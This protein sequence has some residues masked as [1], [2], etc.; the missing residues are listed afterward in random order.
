LGI[1]STLVREKDG[2]EMVYVPGG[3]F[4]M[5]STD[6]EIDA[7]VKKCDEGPG[8]G[9]C[10]RTPY[11]NQSPQHLV[12]LDSF[13]MDR[14]EVTNAQYARCV[15]DGNC[16]P[17]SESGS[18]TR[19]S[20]YG[21]SQ[22]DDYPV[23][24]V[25]WYG[26]DTYCRW[27]G[28]RL[29]TEAEWEYAARGPD[30]MIYPWGNDAPNNTLL[31][32]DHGLSGDTTEV[33]AYPTGAS[34]VGA[35]DMAGNVREWVNDWYDSDYYASSP[36]HNPQGPGTGDRKVRR[37]AGWSTDDYQNVRATKRAYAE[38][39]SRGDVSVGFRCVA[40]PGS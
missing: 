3:S 40:E 23:L 21:D 19:D 30:G 16:S 12:T 39:D 22:F 33:G 2:M 32:Y 14:T 7:Q 8:S 35:V 31:N 24:Y 27:A 18:W 13:W 11:E 5:G 29:P 15:A 36:L 1:G 28:G 26:A 9:N 17:P 4:Q 20:Y 34:W 6:A 10:S 37:G 38:P 25:S